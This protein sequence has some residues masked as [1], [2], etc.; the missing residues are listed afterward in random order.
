MD[1]GAAPLMALAS[2]V[3]ACFECLLGDAKAVATHVM[4]GICVL[5][6]VR[7]VSGEPS[8]AWG[9]QYRSFEASFIETRIAPVLC[10][11][12]ICVAE[13]GSP[14]GLL[15]LNS[16]D[17]HG[18]PIFGEPFHDLSQARYGLTDIVTAALRIVW[19][20]S[21][22]SQ[23][24]VNMAYL[25]SVLGRW[26]ERF[27][28]LVRRRESS[29]SDQDRG[30]ADLIRAMWQST[31]VGLSAGSAADETAW[32]GHKTAYENILRL[33]ESLIAR[34]G[35]SPRCETTFHFE[36]GII[37]PLHLVAWKCRWPDLRRKGL[38]LLLSCSR[39]ECLYDARL[40]YAVFSR[41]MEIEE[42]INALGPSN[43]TSDQPTLPPEQA[44]VHHFHCEPHPSDTHGET[45]ILKI[46]TRP[47]WP[48]RAWH[49]QVEPLRVG[50]SEALNQA[51]F[52]SNTVSSGS[53]RL[54]VVNLFRTKPVLHLSGSETR[55]QL[56]DQ[57]AI[58]TVI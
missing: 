39:Q 10:T 28:D 56:P 30:G 21:V 51:V 49:L 55:K 25:R 32:D 43:Q 23:A 29:W 41:I 33:V 14:G 27:D 50:R 22:S 26:E 53:Q 24:T 40:Y 12:S 11:L 57:T 18:C 37:S 47:N 5:K 48:D 13:F 38:A 3:F 4:S 15:Y 2:I 36:M 45:H 46:F 31:A 42:G 17:G 54:P 8:G 20:D 44:R 7:E 1:T 9:L 58:I 34:Q 35:Y 19:E 16:V 52:S 6:M